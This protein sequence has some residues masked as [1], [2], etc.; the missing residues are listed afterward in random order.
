[1]ENENSTILLLEASFMP[2]IG[3]YN[4]KPVLGIEADSRY[5]RHF[6]LDC[7]TFE[8]EHFILVSFD[9]VGWAAY[10]CDTTGDDI[11]TRFLPYYLNGHYV[12]N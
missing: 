9:W 3:H 12:L 5:I 4:G 2:V 10:H 6:A 8:N 11:L 7:P 1:M